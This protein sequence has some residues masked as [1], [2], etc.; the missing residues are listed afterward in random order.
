MQSCQNGKGAFPTPCRIHARN[1]WV[2][3][4]IGMM[5]LIKK[6]IPLLLSF[7]VCHLPI[8]IPAVDYHFD[9]F[10]MIC[11]A[12]KQTTLDTIFTAVKEFHQILES[13]KPFHW[14]SITIFTI[15][16]KKTMAFCLFPLEHCLLNFLLLH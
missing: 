16:D 9:I 7:I 4:I 6:Y 2:L 3:S 10:S 8:S 15:G 1:N 12:P 14:E 5:F 11:S 13:Q